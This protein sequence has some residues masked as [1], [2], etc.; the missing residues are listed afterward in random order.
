MKDRRHYGKKPVEVLSARDFKI[1]PES[2]T[3]VDLKI[4]CHQRA[5]MVIEGENPAEKA[6]VLFEEFLKPQ[7]YNGQG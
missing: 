5:G 4:L 7:L 6:R 1:L 2:E 3:L